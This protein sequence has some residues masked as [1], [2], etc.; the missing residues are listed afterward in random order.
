MSVAMARDT[1][2]GPGSEAD[3]EMRAHQRVGPQILHVAVDRADEAARHARA[4]ANVRVL[5]AERIL[6]PE[7]A[8]ADAGERRSQSERLTCRRPTP[9]PTT[10]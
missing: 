1:I 7:A 8:G 3:R 6:E 2:A 10:G 9:M 4:D 5:E